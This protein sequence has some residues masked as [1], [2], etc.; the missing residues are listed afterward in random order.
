MIDIFTLFSK[1]SAAFDMM[2]STVLCRVMCTHL[3]LQSWREKVE[4]GKI[5][6]RI[7]DAWKVSFGW[8]TSYS[9]VI[10]TEIVNLNITCH[11]PNDSSCY[12]TP[13]PPYRKCWNMVRQIWAWDREIVECLCIYGSNFFISPAQYRIWK[14]EKL[15]ESAIS[16]HML[17]RY[18]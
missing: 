13:N 6:W 14:K 18:I 15:S 10:I 12:Y 9:R 3:W 17:Y 11:Q 16:I 2:H 7:Y 4:N 5:L 8:W 1:N